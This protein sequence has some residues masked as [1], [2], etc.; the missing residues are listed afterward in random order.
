LL[1]GLPL[2]RSHIP[3]LASSLRVRSCPL[4]THTCPYQQPRRPPPLLLSL[5]RASSHTHTHTYTNTHTQVTGLTTPLRLVM[6]AHVPNQ[7][8]D[9]A[10]GR[11]TNVAMCAYLGAGGGAWNID[12]MTLALNSS[13]ASPFSSPSSM[14]AGGGQ[15]QVLC[16]SSHLT[17]FS[18]TSEP[19]GCD[20]VA[21]GALVLDRCARCGGNNSCVDCRCLCDE[22]CV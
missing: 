22:V 9:P 3:S 5:S 8:R 2:S 17:S 12:G 14:T 6:S 1:V 7:V 16:E 10:T 21:R 15:R 13:S 11:Y 4:P 18:V 19:A 20:Y